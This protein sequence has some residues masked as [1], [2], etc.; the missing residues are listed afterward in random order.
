MKALSLKQPWARLVAL[1][2]KPVENRRWSTRYRGPFL[3]HASLSW[4][5]EGADWIAAHFPDL[6]LP[7]KGD[8]ARGG[9]VG[10]ATLVDVV[11]RQDAM[12]YGFDVSSPWF[13]GPYGF[14]LSDAR[15]L[16]FRAC[17]GTLGFFEVASDPG[18]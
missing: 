16:E 18:A 15:P 17:R 12:L 3:V 11:R 10:M 6:E 5:H 9:I 4:D 8:H 1:G 2:I 7:A 14:L 13:F